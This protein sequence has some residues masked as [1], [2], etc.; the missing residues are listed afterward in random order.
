MAGLRVAPREGRLGTPQSFPG[1]E[2]DG[3]AV[4][5]RRLL[6][7]AE[8][9]LGDTIQFARFARTLA[10]AGSDVILEV[11]PRLVRLC[12]RSTA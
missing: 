8:Q 2:W 7:Y 11:Q 10:E 4:P 6:L 5:G 12:N 3:K 9:A 1:A